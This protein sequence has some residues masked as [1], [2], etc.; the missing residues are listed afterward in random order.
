M[1]F[2]IIFHNLNI[3]DMDVFILKNV[4]PWKLMIH[5]LFYCMLKLQVG[6]DKEKCIVRISGWVKCEQHTE[7]LSDDSFLKKYRITSCMFISYTDSW[8][9]IKHKIVNQHE[10][11]SKNWMNKVPVYG[12]L[13]IKFNSGIRLAVFLKL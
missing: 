1:N 7:Q 11:L 6:W 9:Q 5:S 13:I 10:K 2:D 12:F 4:P 8:L 3:G